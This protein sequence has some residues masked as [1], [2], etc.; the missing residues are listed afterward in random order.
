MIKNIRSPLVYYPKTINE[1]LSLYK[2]MPDSLLYAGG[3][4]ILS[5]RNTK[6]PELPPNILFLRRIDELSAIRRSEGYLEIGACARLNRILG[7]GEHVLKPALY[8]AIKNIATKEVRNIATLGGN[9][10]SPYRSKTLMPLLALLDAR[11][12]LRK[13]GG[14]RW[15]NVRKFIDPDEG[16]QEGE[17]LT[18]VRIPFNNYNHQSFIVTGDR[19]DYRSA[20]TFACFASVQKEN[21]ASIKFAAGVGNKGIFRARE[22]EEALA[23]RKL[24]LYGI[25]EDPVFTRLTTALKN[26]E[27]EISSFHRRQIEGLFLTF[28]HSLNDML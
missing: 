6:Y 4:G 22:F 2:S 24:P 13:Q 18:R 28:M 20:L 8:A 25:T 14:S 9:I 1:L 3:T 19:A 26:Q 23:G 27:E 11:I 16:F 21:I 12:E 5:T 10:C 17:V 7:I 15:L